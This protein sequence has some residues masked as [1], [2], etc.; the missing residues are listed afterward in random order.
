MN[1]NPTRPIE[2]LTGNNQG[3][4]RQILGRCHCC[5]PI[6]KLAREARPKGMRTV[7]VALRRGWAKCVIETNKEQRDLYVSVMRGA[8]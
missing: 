2:D 4:V 8:F 5:S 7:P 6:L 1:I 3:I